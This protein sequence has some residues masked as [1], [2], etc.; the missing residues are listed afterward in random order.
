MH[1]DEYAA[2][3]KADWKALDAFL[4]KKYPINEEEIVVSDRTYGWDGEFKVGDK[5]EFLGLKGVVNGDLEVAYHW[6]VPVELKKA[7]GRL[8]ILNADILKKR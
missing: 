7:E 6:Q 4:D 2:W 1:N 8:V 5:V 3:I